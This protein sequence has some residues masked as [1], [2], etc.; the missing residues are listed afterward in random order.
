MSLRYEDSLSHGDFEREVSMST[1]IR[2]VGYVGPYYCKSGEILFV[3]G[4][5]FSAFF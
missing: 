3:V 1:S 5:K 2:C 4:V